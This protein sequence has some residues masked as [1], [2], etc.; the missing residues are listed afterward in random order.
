MTA[1]IHEPT[2]LR[3]LQKTTFIGKDTRQKPLAFRWWEPEC[4]PC[5]GIDDPVGCDDDCP[6]DPAP[7][8][9][10][11]GF[12]QPDPLDGL[13]PFAFRLH[14][15]GSLE[16]KGHLDATAAVSGTVAVTLP[17]ANAGEIDFRPA[18]D[19]YW[20]TTIID[21][22]STFTLALVLISATTGEVTISWPAS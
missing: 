22:P 4:V 1:N 5:V 6:D 20:H 7:P 2:G 16:F 11:N 3:K 9:L 17:G 10:E 15:D 18:L 14:A 13:E 19:Q 21:P 8:A 12:A